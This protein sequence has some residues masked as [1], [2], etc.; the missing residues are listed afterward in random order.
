MSTQL[1]EAKSGNST[2]AMHTVA[3]AEGLDAEQIRGGVAAGRI[4]I[5]CNPHHSR[6]TPVGIGC[7]LSTKINANIGNSAVS[8]DVG[9]E[10]DKL[11]MAVR[12]GADAIMDLSTG[13]E[14][15]RIRSE[16]LAQCT[17]PVG[18][19]PIYQALCMVDDPMDISA[20]LLLEVIQAQAEQGVDFMTLHAGLLH[21]HLPAARERLLGIVSRGGAITAKWMGR[22]EQE[23]PLYTHFDE[24]LAICREHDVTVSLG[25]G[26]RP[27]CLADAS[28][29]AQFGELEILGELVRRCREAGVQVMVEGPGH[30]PLDQIPMNMAKEREICDDAP[31]Y[32]L[33]PV[34]TDCAPGYDHLTSAIGAA[35]GAWHGAAMLCYVTPKE[36]LGLPNARDVR[37]G[38]VAYKIAAHA[39]DIAKGVPKARDRDDAIS[40]ARASFDWEQQFELAL[41]PER[42]RE[43]RRE[44]LEERGMTPDGDSD[45]PEKDQYCTMCGP[46]FCSMRISQES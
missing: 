43:L 31:F 11:E 26:L 42:A 39:A 23:N 46:K 40:R 22:H 35:V 16:I 2:P 28:D 15:E 25:D 38:V 10:V 5:P 7:E 29:E 41:D 1:L 6:L 30:V 20:Q 37:D 13:S 4:V 32:I 18:T 34:V 14:V 24:V 45:A 44:A 21:R 27:G 9:Q 36:H 3:A 19:V 33:G 8:S 12:Y 17:A